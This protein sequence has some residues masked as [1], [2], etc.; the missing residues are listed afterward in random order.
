MLAPD[1]RIVG[2]G[3]QNLAVGHLVVDV[4]PREGTVEVGEGVVDPLL[5]LQI[6]N[7][8]NCHV[9][10]ESECIQFEIGMRCKSF[11]VQHAPSLQAQCPCSCPAS[12]AS[13]CLE[14]Q[15]VMC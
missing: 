10:C 9:K 13:V 8:L 3:E 5:H 7:F 11:L 12:W 6:P 4:P 1:V 14:T 2:V 15:L